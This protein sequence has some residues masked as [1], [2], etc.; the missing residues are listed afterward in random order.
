MTTELW[1]CDKCGPQ[2]GAPCRVTITSAPLTPS[3]ED[4]TRFRDRRCPC[5]EDEYPEWKC[6]KQL[7]HPVEPEAEPVPAPLKRN[8]PT[9]AGWWRANNGTCFE[10]SQ[11]EID[12]RREWLN[13]WYIGPFRS[14]Q[15]AESIEPADP[16]TEPVAEVKPPP[17][18]Q[19]TA[20]HRHKCASDRGCDNVV[21]SANTLCESC[22]HK[23]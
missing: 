22:R 4:N 13:D 12:R 10:W 17:V 14:R 2:C 20:E 18:K 16:T 21:G 19:Q 5:R 11:H 6:I 9:C 8:Q 7:S 1:E 23:F 15:E 3:M